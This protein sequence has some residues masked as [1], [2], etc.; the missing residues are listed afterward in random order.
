M[1]ITG[2]SL[3]LIAAAS[4]AGLSIG[5]SSGSRKRSTNQTTA[6]TTSGTTGGT[7][8]GTTGG[9]GTTIGPIPSNTGTTGGG[10]AGGGNTSSGGSG[11][12]AGPGGFA[13]GTGQFVDATN[14]LPNTNFQDYGADAADFDGDGRVDIAIAARNGDTRVLF[15]N[16]TSGFSTRANTFPFINMAATDIR[17]VDVDGDGDQDL[18][19]SSNMEPVRLFTNNGAGVFTL[20]QEFNVGNDAFTYNIAL[21]DADG[22][23]DEDVF[24]ANAG[25]SVASQGQNK[26]FLNGAGR[27]TEAPQGSI[28]PRADDSLDA[29]FLDVDGDGDKDIFVANFGTAHSL[30]IND[31]TG[32]FVNQGDVWLPTGL[33]RYGTAIAQGD[34]D[35]DGKI[36]LYVC[37][38]GVGTGGGLPPGEKNSLLIQGTGR[39]TDESTRIPGETEASFAVRLVDVNG[40][41]W[42][43]VLV[44]NLRAVQRLYLNQQGVLVDATATNLPAVNQTP[45]DSLGLTIGDFNGDRAPDVLFVRRGQKPWLFLNIP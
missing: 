10:S 45:W 24:L 4:T 11:S 32:R 21:G 30:L 40:D 42:Q 26:L 44:S 27:F 41:G 1:R 17:A 5:C 25:Q 8:S 20:A 22:D 43:D 18:L 6:A 39:F 34:L 31:G 35:R 13:G 14:L 23:G 38:E 15:N 2:T 29:T 33:T 16:G 36:D 28:P 3:L 19:V 37:N 7:T 9:G 12:G